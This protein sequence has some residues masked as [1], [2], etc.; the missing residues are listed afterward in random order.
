MFS[1]RPF[2]AGWGDPW[3]LDDPGGHVASIDDPPASQAVRLPAE[4]ALFAAYLRGRSALWAFFR[5]RT[6]DEG[7]AEDLLQEV[8]LRIGKAASPGRIRDPDA[9]LRTVAKNLATDWHRRRARRPSSAGPLEHAN[10]PA[11]DRPSAFDQL[12]AHEA[13]EFLMQVLEELSPRR[14]QALLLHKFEGLTMA[15]AARRMGTSSETVE[16]QVAQALAHCQA[17]LIEFGWKP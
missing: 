1:F 11:C 14:R 2:R 4:A 7:A 9:F 15:E 16:R 3:L 12:A 8:W 6:R 17:R 5:L 10:D 13:V